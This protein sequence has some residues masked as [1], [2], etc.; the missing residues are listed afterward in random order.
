MRFYAISLF[1]SDFVVWF[2]TI[3][4]AVEYEKEQLKFGFGAHGVGAE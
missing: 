2:H 3:Y 1:F 4:S